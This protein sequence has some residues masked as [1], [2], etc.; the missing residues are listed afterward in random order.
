MD[1]NTVENVA[2]TAATVAEAMVPGVAPFSP[3]IGLVLTAIK[4]H[5]NAT[6]TWPTEAEVMAAVPADY[7]ELQDVWAKWDASKKG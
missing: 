1:A 7:M 4:A 6:G 5:F 3:I 2:E